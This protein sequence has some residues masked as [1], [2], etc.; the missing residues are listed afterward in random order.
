MFIPVPVIV[1]VTMV[2][3]ILHCVTGTDSHF[4]IPVTVGVYNLYLTL[5]RRF[6]NTLYPPDVGIPPTVSEII[7]ESRS[8]D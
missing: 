8:Q 5:Y 4:K 3:G 7:G 6:A 2:P 1:A